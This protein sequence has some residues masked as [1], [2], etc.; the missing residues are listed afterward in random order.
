MYTFHPFVGNVQAVC[1]V[2]AVLP[3]ETFSGVKVDTPVVV[4]YCLYPHNEED[5]TDS[6][7]S[8][9]LTSEEEASLLKQFEEFVND[10]RN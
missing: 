6:V 8:R 9:E 4:Q 10:Y 3:D 7:F 2:L 1:D 5:A